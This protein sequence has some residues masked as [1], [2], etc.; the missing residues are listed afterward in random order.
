M[1]E[2][3]EKLGHYGV[4]SSDDDDDDDDCG[5]GGKDDDILFGVDEEELD[6]VVADI[7][8]KSS[9]LQGIV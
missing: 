2:I 1:K 3:K 7:F 5:N 6:R 4:E 8:E 9:V